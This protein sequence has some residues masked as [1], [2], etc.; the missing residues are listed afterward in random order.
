MCL[1]GNCGPWDLHLNR[2]CCNPPPPP[3]VGGGGRGGCA[4]LL[5]ADWHGSHED[6][7]YRDPQLVPGSP[8]QGGSQTG[9]MIT[10]PMI[11]RPC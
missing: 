3:L 2:T 6:R 5:F 8:A 4:Q 1:L 7:M 11:Q 9:G 10:R